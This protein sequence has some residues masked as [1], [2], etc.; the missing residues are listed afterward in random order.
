[1]NIESK[2]IKFFKYEGKALTILDIGRLIR[3]NNDSVRY[4]PYL[5]P[6][7][8]MTEE[9]K[10]KYYTFQYKFTLHAHEYQ[11]LNKET[12]SE[13]LN[14]LLENHFD[15]NGLIPKNL[16]IDCTGLNIY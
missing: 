14:W 1:M 16:A 5:R 8:S 2:E 9:E 15:Y 3:F 10:E 4:K 11:E 7:S 6:M 12:F 13:Y